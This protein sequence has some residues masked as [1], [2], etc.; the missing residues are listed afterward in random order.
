MRNKF[1]LLVHESTGQQYENLFVKIMSYADNSFQPVKAYGNIGDRGN[2]GWCA[3][4]GKYFQVYAPEDLPKNSKQAIDKMKRDFDK[5]ISYWNKISPIK[6]F[7][8]VVNDKF[9]GIS[10]HLCKA[11]DELKDIHNLQVAKPLLAKD[12][13]NLL[14]AQNQDVINSVLNISYWGDNQKSIYENLVDELTKIMNLEYWSNISENLIANAIDSS[15]VDG[16]RE[17]GMIVF[18]TELPKTIPSFE[19]SVE[20]LIS[21]T[22][23]LVLHF[24]ESEFTYLTEDRRFW[25]RDM[26]WKHDWRVDQGEKERKF[27]LC[28]K[29]R[30]DLY[31][32]HCNLVVALNDFSREVRSNINST[33]LMGKKFTVVDSIGTYNNLIGYEAIPKGYLDID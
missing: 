16:F 26:R 13:E 1:K 4:Q 10:P 32:L 2:D 19:K 30:D 9:K 31:K 8:F 3:N 20:E 17:A 27:E 14:F 22:K 7:Y 23:A 25:R 12:L 24:T 29:W 11:I 18:K 6:K 15:V 5:L 21:R 33:Y 28:E